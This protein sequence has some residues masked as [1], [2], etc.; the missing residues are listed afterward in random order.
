MYRSAKAP[1]DFDSAFRVVY[2]AA[3]PRSVILC[4]RHVT[5]L[6]GSPIFMMPEI[7][8]PLALQKASG[9]VGNFHSQQPDNQKRVK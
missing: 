9:C 3:L 1:S 8:C 2:Y 5:L 6:V 7:C 4:V